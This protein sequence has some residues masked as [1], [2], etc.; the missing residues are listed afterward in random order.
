MLA[1]SL[2]LLGLLQLVSAASA[3]FSLLHIAEETFAEC[4][5][6]IVEAWIGDS[7]SFS[8]T[9]IDAF[10]LTDHVARDMLCRE[11]DDA[12]VLE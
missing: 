4:R 3:S 11:L 7:V 8:A 6:D 10:I 5:S 9:K 12:A 1:V 2:Q